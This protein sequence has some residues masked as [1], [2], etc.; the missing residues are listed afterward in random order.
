MKEKTPKINSLVFT[1]KDQQKI[2]KSDSKFFQDENNEIE[3]SMKNKRKQKNLFQKDYDNIYKPGF[4][5]PKV[6]SENLGFYSKETLDFEQDMDTENKNPPYF[7]KRFR[8]MKGKNEEEKGK[9]Q[10][11]GLRVGFYY[12]NRQ[13]DLIDNEEELPELAENLTFEVKM[14]EFHDY[15][16]SFKSFLLKNIKSRYILLTT[17]DR[18]SVVYERYMRAGNFAAQLSMFA[19]VLSIFFTADAEQQVFVSKDRKQIPNFILY[20]FAADVLGCI[21]VHLPAYCFWVNDKKFRQLYTTIRKDGG[22]HVLKQMEDIVKKGRFFW[23][24]LGIIIQV[25]FIVVGFYFAFGFCAT[26]YYQRSTFTLALICTL[27]FDF[28]VSEFLWEII[29]GLLFYIRDC[30]RII[31]FLGTLFNTLRNIKHLV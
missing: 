9:G 7:G 12:K 19:F 10:N 20:C 24:L 18:T 25:I 17:F 2:G 15:S 4:K 30:G 5:G 3:K 28:L 21:A 22:I 27:G 1:E 26:Y 29:I 11:A 13:I 6:V 16:V 23:N 14:E 31:V 8:K